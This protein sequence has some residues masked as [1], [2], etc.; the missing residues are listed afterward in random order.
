MHS[1]IHGLQSTNPTVEWV[2]TSRVV[3]SDT[4]VVVG[5]HIVGETG[6]SKKK[7]RRNNY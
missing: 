1:E 3:G 2:G 7:R 4:N 6:E 5:N